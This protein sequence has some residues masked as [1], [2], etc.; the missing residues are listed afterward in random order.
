VETH[1][2]TSEKSPMTARVYVSLLESIEKDMYP[3]RR[4]FNGI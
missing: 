4:G 2:Q 1:L 3:D